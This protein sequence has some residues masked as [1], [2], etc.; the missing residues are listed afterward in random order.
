[1]GLSSFPLNLRNLELISFK[2]FAQYGHLTVLN[3]E[4]FPLSQAFPLV[5][6]QNSHPAHC[7]R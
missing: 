7:E 6:R 3:F 2:M 4:V 1:M 5:F